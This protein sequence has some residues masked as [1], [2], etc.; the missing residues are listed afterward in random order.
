MTK[1]HTFTRRIGTPA[2]AAPTRFPP[3]AMTR[4]PKRVRVSSTAPRI[5]IASTQRISD[6]SQAP[7][8]WPPKPLPVDVV[9]S[10]IGDASV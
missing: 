8:I 1:D 9:D 6:H 3:V 10:G 5:A 7:I 2:S 4:V